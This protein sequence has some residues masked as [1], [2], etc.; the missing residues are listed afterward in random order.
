V[1]RNPDP[2]G[3]LQ[4]VTMSVQ[5]FGIPVSIP[6]QRIAFSADMID[7]R[8]D[9]DTLPPRWNPSMT[10]FA[11]PVPPDQTAVD[12][13]DGR[14]VYLKLSLSLTGWTYNDDLDIGVTSGANTKVDGVQ[15]SVWEA[16]IA[17][18]WANAY[19]PCLGAVAQ[20]A[21]YPLPAER[22]VPISD[23]PYIVDFEPKK[24]E[25]LETVSNTG[26]VLTGTSTGTSV[27]KNAATLGTTE[28]TDTTTTQDLTYVPNEYQV[29][30]LPPPQPSKITTTTS[31]TRTN[32]GTDTVNVSSTDTLREMRETT[33]A[34][35]TTSQLYQ[36]FNGYHVGTN[37]GVFVVTPRP[38]T[39]G[40]QAQ[41]EFN[42][43]DGPRKLEGVQE[44]FLVVYLP[45]SLHGFCVQAALD[46]GHPVPEST[47]SGI[48]RA[49]YE[50]Y[51]LL[52]IRRSIKTCASFGESG[53]LVPAAIEPPK[54][55]VGTRV[56][57]EKAVERFAALVIAVLTG[58][59]ETR[60]DRARAA[61]AMNRLRRDV[62]SALQ[63]GHAGRGYR[64][65]SFVETDV[66]RR[67]V[68]Q[69]LSGLELKVSDLGKKYLDEGLAKKLSLARLERVGQL[70]SGD[71]VGTGQVSAAEI[72]AVRLKL[73]DAV[74]KAARDWQK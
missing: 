53:R 26:E 68:A 72:D 6:W 67:A 30:N 9:D 64:A 47:N 3:W 37:R 60:P 17:S 8:F 65:R 28:Q 62:A 15:K 50:G 11:Y 46:T 33:S 2:D 31:G 1:F 52:V 35:T 39:V 56:I 18:D 63:V 49:I 55:L 48:Q 38:H 58:D 71:A 12:Y 66:V 10:V 13:P 14:L 25:L 16:I 21:V 32:S 57:S 40:G 20:L 36:L 43:I 73:V 42:L 4:N 41:T 74:V 22:D 51:N 69:A 54:Y 59:T 44:V 24:R 70:F 61:D 19:A 5:S 45:N 23:Y 29:P 34:T 27:Q 7:R